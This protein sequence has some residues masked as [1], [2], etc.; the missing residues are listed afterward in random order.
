MR[1]VRR[2]AARCTFTGLHVTGAKSQAL[3]FQR[4]LGELVNGTLAGPPLSRAARSAALTTSCLAATAGWFDVMD[5]QVPS[6]LIQ[7]VLPVR[8]HSL[9]ED[10]QFGTHRSPGASVGLLG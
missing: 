9:C 4:D 3:R 8:D 7:A 2:H 1:Y 10:L 5:C 6:A